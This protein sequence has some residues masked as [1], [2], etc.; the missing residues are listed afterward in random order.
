VLFQHNTQESNEMNMRKINYG[1][2]RQSYAHL[3]DSRVQNC[4]LTFAK[5]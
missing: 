5:C 3:D 4:F 1:T 2:Q